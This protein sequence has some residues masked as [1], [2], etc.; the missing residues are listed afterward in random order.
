MNFSAFELL[1]IVFLGRGNKWGKRALARRAR[2]VKR[3]DGGRSWA[4]GK[5]GSLED[6]HVFPVA[7]FPLL[8]LFGWN[9]VSLTT[10]EH[11]LIHRN[12]SW[13]WF[14]FFFWWRPVWGIGAVLFCWVVTSILL[15]PSL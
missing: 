6:H 4:S 5:R 7:I 8:S 10:S 1:S 3:R 2:Y 11:D 15:N 9:G 14:K 12:P 13:F